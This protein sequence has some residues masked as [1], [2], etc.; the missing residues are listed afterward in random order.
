MATLA[1][2][3]RDFIVSESGTRLLD[4]GLKATRADENSDDEKLSEW[5][6]GVHWKKH[7]RQIKRKLSQGYLLIKMSF[8]NCGMKTP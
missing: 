1:M 6:V 2:M 3:I 8:V 5:V 4:A 7:F